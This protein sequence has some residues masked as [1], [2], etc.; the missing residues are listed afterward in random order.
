MEDSQEQQ[1]EREKKEQDNSEQIAERDAIK[2]RKIK[3]KEKKQAEMSAEM[4][5]AIKKGLHHVLTQNLLTQKII[6]RF[7]FNKHPKGLSSMR[8]DDLE[9]KLIFYLTM[10]P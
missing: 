5:D 3:T 7:Y 9:E 4:K 10:V 8:W 6:I 2:K 1:V